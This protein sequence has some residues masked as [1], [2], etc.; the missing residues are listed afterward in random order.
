M[1]DITALGEILIDFT[2]N[3]TNEQGIS[4]FAQNPGGAPANVLAMNA[5]LG[6]TSA[7]IGKV[8]SDAFG[9]YLKK[10]LEKHKI[11]TDGLVSDKKI[12]TTLAFVQL[13]ETGDR[14]FTFYRN[15][16]ADLCLT[17]A[18]VNKDLIDRCKV[19]HFGSLSLTDDPCRTTIIDAV[20]YAKSKGKI[21]SFDPNYRPPLWSDSQKAKEL[22]SSS[23]GYADILKVSEEEMTL[24]TDETD[25]E[26]GSAALLNMGSK[27]VFV[28][29]GEKGA[30]FRNHKGYGFVPA[31]T[32]SAKD[33]T[34]AGDAFMGTIL[35]Q[36]KDK[37]KAELELIDLNKVTTFANAA[38]GLTAT[39]KG[40]IPSLLSYEEIRQL[41]KNAYPC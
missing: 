41:I 13:D 24:I 26:K 19:F 17:K 33:T 20:E 9:T 31:F 34:G 12:P 10:V 40:A 30:C 22:I 25:P 27:C 11:N 4:L 29:L 32:V 8:G 1:I 6:G 5:K 35:W 21:I 37:S 38:G 36:L 7:F 14:S 39:E 3:G 2:P 16:G 23:V 28:T 18:E 15:P